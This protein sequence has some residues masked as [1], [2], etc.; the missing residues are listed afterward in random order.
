M[1]D[2]EFLMHVVL[3]VHRIGAGENGEAKRRYV[4]DSPVPS[5][6]HYSRHKPKEIAGLPHEGQ[7]S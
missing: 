6:E 5:G 3:D 1:N 2:K 4:M 7:I